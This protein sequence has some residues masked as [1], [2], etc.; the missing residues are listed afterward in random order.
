MFCVSFIT[1]LATVI[2]LGIVY[3]VPTVNKML[4]KFSFTTRRRFFVVCGLFYMTVV[5][6][7]SKTTKDYLLFRV[8]SIQF[9][10]EYSTFIWGAIYF[11]IL[12]VSIFEE[13]HLNGWIVSKGKESS[14]INEKQ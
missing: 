7:Y 4:N 12:Y 14:Q 3:F 13:F 8:G 1:L 5:F 2:I 9:H 10:N 6:L 11:L